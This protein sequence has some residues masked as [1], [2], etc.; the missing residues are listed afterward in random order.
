MSIAENL[1]PTAELAMPP[2]PRRALSTLGLIR[3]GFSNTL[4]MCDEELFD[5]L[6]VERRFFWGRVFFVSDPDGIKRVLQDNVDNYPRIDAIRRVFAFGSGTGMLSAEGEP[7]RRHRRMLNPTMDRRAL[8]ADLPAMGRLAEDLATRIASRP[9]DQEFTVSRLFTRL[10]SYSTAEVLAGEA[11]EVE[12]MVNHMGHFPGEYS[13]SD[14]CTL[15]RWLRFL[16]RSRRGEAE[17]TRYAPL[18]DRLVSSRRAPS[19]AGAKDLMWRIAHATDRQTGERLTDPELHDEVLT[20]ASTSVTALHVYSWLWYLLA[21]HPWAGDEVR[22]EVDAVLGDRLPEAGDLGRLVFTR[23]VIDETMRLYPPLPIML[24]VASEP[25]VICGHRIP[26]KS[27]IAVMPWVVHRHRKLWADPDRFDPE[28]FTPQAIAARSRYAYL[29]FSAG[30]RVCIGATMA[31]ME[32][33][34]TV[35]V[36]ARRLR[37]RLVPGQDI[38]PIAW[39]NLRPD[40][41]IRMTVERRMHCE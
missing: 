39:T 24:R 15:P 28:R 4:S 16:N 29:P 17:A 23:K 5:E 2:R 36:I 14:F 7:W 19:Y 20:L 38:Q 6:F 12:A 1:E 30:P 33:V 25:D 9:A 21:I 11:G 18:I 40:G 31:L 27:Y 35:A 26:R 3:T 41:G 37:F 34:A 10:L 32:M 22:A 13:L 8:L